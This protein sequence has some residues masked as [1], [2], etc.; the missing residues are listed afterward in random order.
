MHSPASA[1]PR[2]VLPPPPPHSTSLNIYLFFCTPISF[3]CTQRNGTLQDYRVTGYWLLD[4]L[5]DGYICFFPL[6]SPFFLSLSS[7]SI[8]SHYGY[9]P[10]LSLHC[11]LPPPSHTTNPPCLFCLP[12]HARTHAASSSLHITHYTPHTTLPTHHPLYSTDT[13][14]AQIQIQQIQIQIQQIR[15]DT[16]LDNYDTICD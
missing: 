1:Y 10:P 9:G 7:F 4:G 6:D 16:I 14:T 13:D 11:V 2:G 8:L 5:V 15:Y 3:F 12:T